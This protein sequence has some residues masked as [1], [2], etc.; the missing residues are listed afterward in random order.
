MKKMRYKITNWKQYNQIWLTI[1]VL[2]SEIKRL[3]HVQD[4][5]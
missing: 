5:E 1:H 4:E 2:A 3:H